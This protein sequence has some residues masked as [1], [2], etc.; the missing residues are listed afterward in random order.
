MKCKF[1]NHNNDKKKKKELKAHAT[2]ALKHWKNYKT[3][4]KE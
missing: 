2:Q 1:Y 4:Q 3:N